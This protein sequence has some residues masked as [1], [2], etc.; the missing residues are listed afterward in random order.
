MQR[1]KFIN[2]FSI[3]SI[4]THPHTHRYAHG[5]II[6]CYHYVQVAVYASEDKLEQ[7]ELALDVLKSTI[8]KYEAY[9][10]VKYPLPKQGKDI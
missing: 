8:P 3:D 6:L 5:G 7:T 4:N 9:F 2:V 10:G 1:L